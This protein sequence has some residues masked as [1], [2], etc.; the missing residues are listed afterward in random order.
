MATPN[1]FGIAIGH[2]IASG[3]I[4]NFVP[5]QPKTLGVQF[6]RR[7]PTMTGIN[8]EGAYVRFLFDLLSETQWKAVMSQAGLTGIYL[9]RE[10]TIQA[11]DLDFNWT[12][13]NGTAVKPA[14]EGRKGFWFYNVPLLIIDLHEVGT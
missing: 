5:Y 14:N 1:H 9:Q 13:F 4:N 3:S 10:V 12:Y 6:T 7:T 2:N 8:Q 11:Q